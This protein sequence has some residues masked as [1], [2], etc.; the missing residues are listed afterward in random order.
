V[1][2]LAITR[3]LLGALFLFRTSALSHV[4]HGIHAPVIGPLLGWPDHAPLHVAVGGLV[5]PNAVAIAL[6]IV[7][8]V[9]ALAFT[10][11][12][13]ART[14]G[15]VAAGCGWLA[16]AQDPFGFTFTLHV[17]FLAVAVHAFA[18]K[19]SGSSYA[20]TRIFTAS[21][22]FWSAIPKLNAA[23]LSGDVL[24][25]YHA[26]GLGRSAF[27]LDVHAGATAITT[28]VMELAVPVMLLCRRTRTSAVIIACMMH[29]IIE[30]L[31]HP[32][33]FWWLMVVLLVPF[34]PGEKTS[35][36]ASR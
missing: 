18:A 11:G 30:V 12:Y 1:N 14:T 7:R 5:L 3:S 4:A 33:V 35:P 27:F 23:W 24:R 13:R 6:A 17:M 15:L 10:V 19:A 26:L 16:L 2:R 32:D 22:Y 25:A 21:I 29:T 36:S 9:S 34:W 31:Y 20:L 28:V 8:T